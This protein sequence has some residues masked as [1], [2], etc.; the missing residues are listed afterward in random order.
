M[1]FPSKSFLIIIALFFTIIACQK[2]EAFIEE[3]LRPIATSSTTKS[4]P[5]VAKSLWPYFE[6]FEQAGAAH[7]IQVD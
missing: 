3:E 7:G 2:E 4:Y 1:Q 5:G 6:R